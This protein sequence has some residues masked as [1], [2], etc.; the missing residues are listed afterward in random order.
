MR[1][2]LGALLCGVVVASLVSAVSA[3]STATAFADRGGEGSPAWKTLPY[4]SYDS[5]GQYFYV[6]TT[7]AEWKAAYVANVSRGFAFQTQ[8]PET[9][10]NNNLESLWSASCI[11]RK[12]KTVTMTRKVYVPGT[13]STLLVNLQTTTSGGAKNPL[14]SVQLKINGTAVAKTG[15]TAPGA[16]TTTDAT[17]A[18]DA[19][20]FGLNTITIVA[21]KGKTKK[22]GAY[23]FERHSSLG[24]AAEIYGRPQSDLSATIPAWTGGGLSIDTTATVI[25]KGPSTAPGAATDDYFGIGSQDSVSG[26]ITELQVSGP[27][28]GCATNDTAFAITAHCA[29]PKLGKGESAIYSVHIVF[30]PLSCNMNIP[31]GYGAYGYWFDPNYADNGETRAITANFC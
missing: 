10:A 16:W 24:V 4:F 7:R 26:R 6:P 14:N 27:G 5:N 30:E 31:V 9:Q 15:K 28:A 22:P 3:V 20:T 1:F 25:N 19:L 23:C 13:P 29:L 2:R 21:K 8:T 17:N 18:A 12:A 11:K